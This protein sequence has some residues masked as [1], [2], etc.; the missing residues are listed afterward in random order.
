MLDSTG[1]PPCVASRCLSVSPPSTTVWLSRTRSFV[2][3]VR[4]EIT[5]ASN[6]VSAVA[7]LTSCVTSSCT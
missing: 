1:T 5:G 2:C 7:W 3:T 4:V 6:C